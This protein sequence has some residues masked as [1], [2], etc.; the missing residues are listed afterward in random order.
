MYRDA[1]YHLSRAIV[2]AQDLKNGRVRIQV[3]EG[4]IADIVLKGN[5]AEQ[6]GI[7]PLLRAVRTSIRRG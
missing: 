1:G 4:K 5:G 7:R 6:F 2:P 3:I